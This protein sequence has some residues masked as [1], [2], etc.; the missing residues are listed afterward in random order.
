MIADPICSMFIAVLIIMRYASKLCV[1]TCISMY[2][3]LCV[4]NLVSNQIAKNRFSKSRGSPLR[5]ITIQLPSSNQHIHVSI[6][7][8]THMLTLDPPPPPGL[9]NHIDPGL[10]AYFIY[11]YIIS[12]IVFSSQFISIQHN[13][14]DEGV[15]GCPDAEKPCFPGLHSIH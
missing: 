8:M 11:M 4:Y 1:Y 9:L 14:S 6:C 12:W 10:G 2:I 15:P 5:S 13:S 7:H 3:Q